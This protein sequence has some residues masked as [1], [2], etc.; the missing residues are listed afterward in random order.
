MLAK[1]RIKYIYV[2]KAKFSCVQANVLLHIIRSSNGNRSFRKDSE[3]DPSVLLPSSTNLEAHIA[4]SYKM[5]SA[6]FGLFKSKA[7]E[8][9]HKIACSFLS[10]KQLQFSIEIV[11]V[12]RHFKYIC[13]CMNNITKKCSADDQ[14]H[15][16]C[17]Q[18]FC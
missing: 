4:D 9:V 7:K 10:F 16:L 15:K 5:V 11:L 14:I 2:D 8:Q 13:F 17:L 3:I 18:R 6:L 12:V 1:L